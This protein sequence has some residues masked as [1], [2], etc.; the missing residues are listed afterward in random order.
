MDTST[1]V[2]EDLLEIDLGALKS[3]KQNQMHIGEVDPTQLEKGTELVD[4]ISSNHSNKFKL[5]L[6]GRKLSKDE[7]LD[8]IGEATDSHFIS[9]QVFQESGETFS[10]NI[11]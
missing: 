4:D 10:Q 11:E 1:K 9:T 8:T 2:K 3:L 5:V 6:V 7:Q